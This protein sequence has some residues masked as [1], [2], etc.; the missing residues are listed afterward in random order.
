MADN[1]KMYLKNAE[2]TIQTLDGTNGHISSVT[3]D[4]SKQQSVMISPGGIGAAVSNEVYKIKII[5][6]AKD[7]NTVTDT[8]IY[9]I[10]TTECTNC[11]TT[12]HG[13]LYVNGSISTIF[14]MFIPDVGKVI[15]KRYKT[16]SWSAWTPI[17]T[18]NP[19]SLVVKLNS[20]STEGTNM[21][22]YNG[23]S[24][25]SINITPNSIGAA[26]KN[27]SHLDMNMFLNQKIGSSDHPVNLDYQ[28]YS[29]MKT[30][31]VIGAGQYTNGPAEC[32]GQIYLLLLDTD[33]AQHKQIV[34]D[35]NTGYVYQR[36]KTGDSWSEWQLLNDPIIAL[37]STC[38]LN[39]YYYKEWG[40]M[41]KYRGLFG[42][43][44]GNSISNSP[45]NNFTGSAGFINDT[46]LWTYPCYMFTGSKT[47]ATIQ[48][49]SI[50][51]SFYKRIGYYT[52][53]SNAT[54]IPW[55]QI[56]TK[57]QIQNLTSDSG[58][59]NVTTSSD[60]PAYN[61]GTIPKIR[62]IGNI[63]ELRG[64]VKNKNAFATNGSVLTNI[65]SNMRPSQNVYVVQTANSQNMQMIIKT[66]GTVGLERCGSGT[67]AA[68]AWITVCATWFVG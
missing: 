42:S 28:Y 58:W 14:Q 17:Q 10:K 68:D 63:V 4:G 43:S 40:T 60:F 49:L 44:S 18:A 37:P 32:T 53:D 38:D 56:A 21:F 19:T 39:N 57:S 51:G 47:L 26:D 65:P 45:S 2:L 1:N 67:V 64:V 6:S 55:D 22:T 15:Y 30:S 59:L 50:N 27:H 13:T 66:D 31:Y 20:G 9:H 8:G 41:R 5:A 36:L 62:K 16:S 35:F 46:Y 29:G 12:N 23:T 7:W 61:S 11:P 24:A 54:W 34:T 52:G 25:K 3:Y 33:S 48:I